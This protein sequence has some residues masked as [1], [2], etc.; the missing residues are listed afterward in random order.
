MSP[1]GRRVLNNQGTDDY[2]LTFQKVYILGLRKGANNH[3]EMRYASTTSF[4]DMKK[5]P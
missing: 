1:D 2:V 5:A 4:Y 3:E